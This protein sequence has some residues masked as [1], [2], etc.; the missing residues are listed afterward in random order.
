[1]SIATPNGTLKSAATITGHCCL[2]TITHRPDE[3]PPLLVQFNVGE[4]PHEIAVT[5][6]DIQT[7]AS[8]QRAVADRL[9]VWITEPLTSSRGAREWWQEEVGRAFRRA[10]KREEG[11]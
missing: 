8:F 4:T 5:A 9:G 2:G 11:E 3:K 10:A 7:F 6:R 1:M